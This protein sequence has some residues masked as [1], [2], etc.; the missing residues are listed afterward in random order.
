MDK[1]LQ[2]FT[3]LK[4]QLMAYYRQAYPQFQGR[5]WS[6]V[7]LSDIHNFQLLLETKQGARLSEKWIY[8][9]LKSVENTKLP[10]I[11]TLNLLTEFLG[12]QGWDDF[13]FRTPLVQEQTKFRL[14]R[15]VLAVFAITLPVLT[16]IGYWLLPLLSS[17]NQQLCFVDNWERQ[18]ITT[19][20]VQ[21]EIWQEQVLQ[22]RLMS[23]EV[24]C[25][26]LPL[27]EGDATLIISA[28]YYQTDT[29]T[30]T[31]AQLRETPIH[32]MQPDDY[33][34]MIH[35]FANGE[36]DQWKTRR[37]HLQKVIAADAI[38]YQMAPDGVLGMDILNKQSFVN[39]LTL[40]TRNLRG[41]EVL[42]IVYEGEQISE[43]RFRIIPKNETE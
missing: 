5:N 1:A 36:I 26:E 8:T 16:M 12:Y 27:W 24:G 30:A 43:L 3:V 25:L 2:H 42:A 13:C 40:P 33:A 4:A 29:L 18:P 9:H 11:D 10:R 22:Q 19:T 6:D 35:Y 38:I 37:E 34:L 7:R 21:V 28:S 20:L 31:L 32:I 39:Q 14:N 15:K 41:L 23:N 17:S